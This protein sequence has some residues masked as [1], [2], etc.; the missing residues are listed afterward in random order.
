MTA[1]HRTVVCQLDELLD[2]ES[3]GLALCLNEQVR[4]VFIVRKG[5]H[6]YAYLNSCPH[7]GAPLDW[8]PDQF[9]S[10]DRNYI[11]CATHNAL[12]R[13]NDGYC[14]SGPCA[15]ARLTS[16][17]VVIDGGEVVIVHSDFL[18]DGC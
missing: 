8:V 1:A 14:V 13:F 16:V 6:V 17:P 12:F 7:T 18:A 11:Q 4:D 9:L 5:Q 2:P 3:R 15:G 10:L